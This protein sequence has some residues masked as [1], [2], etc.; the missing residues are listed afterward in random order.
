MPSASTDSSQAHFEVMILAAGKGTRMRSQLPKVLHRVCGLTLLERCLRASLG[1]S[2][3]RIVVVAGYGE[4]LLRAEVERLKKTERFSNVEIELARQPEQ[5]GTGH[6][7][8]C[9]LPA[10]SKTADRL[11]I[12]PGDCPLMNED[13][14]REIAKADVS[15]GRPD[16]VVV[17]FEPEIM[18][19]YGRIIRDSA[20]KFLRVTEH[21]DCTPAERSIREVNAS[22]YTT[23]VEFLRQALPKL[24]PK[25]AQ[26]ELYFTDVPAIGR[27][28]GRTVEAYLLSTARSALGANS[29]A[30]LSQ[31]E[32][33]A[34][35][36]INIRIMES[37]VTLEDPAA[38]YI[39]EDVEIGP[40][41]YLGAGTRLYGKTSI[42]GGVHAEGE[43]FVSDS[44]IGADTLLRLGTHIESSLVGAKCKIGP[45]AHLR[46]GSVL[47]DEVHLGNFVETKQTT[48]AK[49][50]KAN[51]LAY[52]GD[53]HVGPGANVG[54]GAITCNY[55]GSKKHRTNIGAGAFIGTNNSLVAPVTIGDGAYTAAGS[56]ITK[57]V[58]AESLGIERSEQ[59]IVEG[60]V[61]RKRVKKAE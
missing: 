2:P 51:H 59:R 29:R 35:E 12:L 50:S 26:N 39:D 9:G 31:L 38:T 19:E 8:M 14:V 47:E 54:A 6:A 11:L 5:R 4:E 16:V 48:M 20:G 56:V 10:I 43:L 49:G 21:K 27:E 13:S 7:V 44:T 25:N 15:L 40:D 41:T 23:S 60:W 32:R 33:I 55:D 36:Q 52:L 22:I 34:R 24:E 28:L 37:G 58:P 18:I 61:S 57:N 30:E 17:S 42:A 53:A 46:P 45:F 1:I 3:R